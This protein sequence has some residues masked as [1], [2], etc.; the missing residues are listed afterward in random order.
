MKKF[1][2]PLILTFVIAASAS[3]AYGRS[4]V[5]LAEGLYITAPSPSSTET[6]EQRR[7]ITGDEALQ[8]ALEHAGVSRN[9]VRD[10]DVDLERERGRLVWEVEFEVRRNGREDEYEYYIDAYTGEIVRWERD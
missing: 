8:I 7:R 3:V 10:I 6:P 9:Q 1:F 2:A 5:T 4:A